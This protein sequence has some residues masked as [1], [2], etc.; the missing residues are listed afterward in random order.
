M[1]ETFCIFVE[2]EKNTKY[3][4]KRTKNSDKLKKNIQD[5][6]ENFKKRTNYY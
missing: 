1:L 6:S 4:K 2:N 3:L 5:K